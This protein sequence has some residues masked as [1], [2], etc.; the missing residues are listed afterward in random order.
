MLR[1][2]GTEDS[3]RSYAGE[4]NLGPNQ[5][6]EERSLG[7]SPEPDTDLN[8]GEWR[9]FRLQ[10]GRERL[11]RRGHGSYPLLFVA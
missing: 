5:Q 1:Q 10:R 8:G 4:A 3:P 11:C 6:G 9:D 2:N 7:S